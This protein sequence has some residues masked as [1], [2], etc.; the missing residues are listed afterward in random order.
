MEKVLFWPFLMWQQVANCQ[1][2]LSSK[3]LI[4]VLT[5]KEKN[6]AQRFTRLFCENPQQKNIPLVIF[7]CNSKK[8]IS[9]LHG[10]LS[11]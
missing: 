5:D 6:L 8:L 3:G 7:T 4:T 9:S 2:P 10:K 1:K 11:H